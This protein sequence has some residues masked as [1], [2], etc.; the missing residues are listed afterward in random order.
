MGREKGLVFLHSRFSD[1]SGS[2]YLSGFF[3]GFLKMPVPLQ[4]ASKM[5]WPWGR[6]RA[7]TKAPE[8]D[9]TRIGT[10]EIPSPQKTL[11]SRLGSF[12][13]AHQASATPCFSRSLPVGGAFHFE[14]P[15]HQI[16]PSPS[17]IRP[18]WPPWPS[19]TRLAD[20]C[21]KQQRSNLMGPAHET[22]SGKMRY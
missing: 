15:A 19:F 18:L 21:S 5:R 22:K 6:N 14:I 4:G 3:T 2:Q 8:R 1:F 20:S 10:Q 16:W 11:R 12:Q 9:A 17:L 13:N 7:A